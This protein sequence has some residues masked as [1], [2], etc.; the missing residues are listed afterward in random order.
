MGGNMVVAMTG[1][2][3]TLNPNSR[4][5]ADR[6]TAAVMSR[7]LPCVFRTNGEGALQ[8][9]PAS[10]LVGPPEVLG[11]S[12]FTIRYTIRS[13]ATWSDGVPITSDDFIWNA[14]VRAGGGPLAAP[15]QTDKDGLSFD[16]SST[17]GYERIRRINRVSEKV[18]EVEFDEPYAEWPLLWSCPNGLIPK[19]TALAV[20][21]NEGWSKGG[22]SAEAGWAVAGGPLRVVSFTPGK[23]VVLE[24]NPRFWGDA[25]RLDRLT[26]RFG[27]DDVELATR[28]NRGE[29]DVAAVR[30]VPHVVDLVR[31][32]SVQP[33]FVPGSS[34]FHLTFNTR[35]PVLRED[36]V[37]MAVATAVD[38]GEL[39]T[40]TLG[41]TGS[42]AT[43]QVCNHLLVRSQPGYQPHCDAYGSGNAA[44][45][46]TVMLEAGYVKG[47]DGVW[48]KGGVPTRFH[49]STE[50]SDAQAVATVGLLR[51]QLRR[52]GFD[53]R[54]DNV[55][56]DGALRNRLVAG[57]FDLAL[58]SL[59]VADLPGRAES[60]YAEPVR[61]AV[62]GTTTSTGPVPTTAAGATTTSIGA[63]TTTRVG[64][65]P[66]TL[67]GQLAL[68]DENY[69]RW[70][71]GDQVA[72]KFVQWRR[73]ADPGRSLQIVH[74][75]DKDLWR[76]MPGMP[77]TQ[78]C[79]LVMVRP[80]LVNIP[81]GA[82]TRSGLLW[83]AEYLGKA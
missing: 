45:A 63:T 41:P 23:E 77:L 54:I 9:D 61:P 76:G 70:S 37:R 67:P 21:W 50:S 82:S 65:T 5:G 73:E 48:A 72:Q 17:A 26:V 6:A 11:R 25:A 62:V 59:A 51:D 12:P 22:Q 29:A 33:T 36:A 31:A 44:R 55:S 79:W 20:G 18:F 49:L 28:V 19:H 80:G 66:A 35:S 4:A 78:R 42:A 38:V 7:V 69:S 64:Q 14:E 52:V 8:P 71:G 24:R 75:I 81:T 10:P 83:E 13:S 58:T 47:S 60:R 32:G 34:V 27:T 43:K 57:D 40:S 53:V 74:D 15:G 68:A 1:A 2:P 39:S 30:P 46:T 56:D 3:K 16:V